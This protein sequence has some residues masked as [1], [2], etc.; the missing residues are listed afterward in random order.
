VKLVRP[1]LILSL[2]DYTGEWSK[3]YRDN[4]YDVVQV[5]LAHGQDV[6]LLELPRE[7][8]STASSRRRPA[9]CSRS[10]VPAGRAP[11]T[12]CAKDS[13]WSTPACG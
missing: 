5:D 4:G 12:R 1:Q 6:R 7:A 11:M 13:L 8:C 9:P 2:C 10:P 3:P